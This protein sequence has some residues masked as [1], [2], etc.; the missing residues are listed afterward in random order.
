MWWGG[1]GFGNRLLTDSYPSLV[2]ITIIV[3]QCIL[4]MKARA[5]RRGLIILF[6]L[7]GIFSI[8]VHSYQG[9][10]NIYTE[11]WNSGLKATDNEGYIF[12]WSGPQFLANSKDIKLREFNDIFLLLKPN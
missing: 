10:Y 7:L 3:F 11:R 8:F 12:S 6:V 2:F 9:L 5:I 4:A 1:G